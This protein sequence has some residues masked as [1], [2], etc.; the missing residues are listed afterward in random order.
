MSAGLSTRSFGWPT[1]H[2]AHSR[3][4]AGAWT[5]PVPCCQ[6]GSQRHKSGARK[7]TK[8]KTAPGRTNT[9]PSTNTSTS[10]PVVHT[11][12][13]KDRTHIVSGATTPPKHVPSHALDE[14]LHR[15][16]LYKL[17]TTQALRNTSYASALCFSVTAVAT[18][19]NYASVA[20]THPV[21]YYIGSGLS[22]MWALIAGY[23]FYAPLKMVSLITFTSRSGSRPDMLNIEF[24]QTLPFFS[25]PGI[26]VP[27]SEVST[28]VPIVQAIEQH[29]ELQAVV[30]QSGFRQFARHFIKVFTRNTFL[31]LAIPNR[32]KWKVDLDPK[33]CTVTDQET[34]LDKALKAGSTLPWWRSA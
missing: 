34:V 9:L 16:I 26:S 24:A 29:R 17:N 4:L 6:V 27:A 11:Q 3:V 12:R 14:T 32:G 5:S 30:Q 31:Y 21:I 2:V 13:L 33:V 28:D 15:S 1:Q 8:A 18:F 23:C 7:Q 25:H 22:A 10:H 20:L 19:Q